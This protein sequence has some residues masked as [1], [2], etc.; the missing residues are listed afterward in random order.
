ML[1]NRQQCTGCGACYNIC[2]VGC[3]QMVPDA[4]GFLAPVVD[5]EQCTGCGQCQKACPE[6]HLPRWARDIAPRVFACWNSNED[7]RLQS[8]SGGLFSAL[9][10]RIFENGG[11]VVGA[12]YAEEL[13]VK[14]IL[15]QDRENAYRLR[16]SKY[17]QSDMGKTYQRVE[18]RLTSGIRVLF[19]GTPCQ[20]A[21]LRG[22]LGKEY[23][24]L[25][26]CDIL[27]HGVPSPL[28]FSS[29]LEYLKNFLGEEVAAINCRDKRYD[30]QRHAVF[31]RLVNSEEKRLSGAQKGY[32]R[33]FYRGL[34]LREACYECRYCSTQRV[35]DISLGDFWGIGKR[36]PFGHPTRRGVSLGIVNTRKGEEL[37]VR[38]DSRLAYEMRPL[39]EAVAGNNCLSLT[40]GRHPDRD[41]FYQDLV[42]HG[43]ESVVR[44]Y[45]LMGRSPLLQKVAGMKAVQRI[46]CGLRS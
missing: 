28:C 14:H 16:N 43:F 44:K 35:G 40:T 26:T 19:S 2:P 1:C 29:Y 30:W 25:I 13:T 4:E 32:F 6:L 8:A 27:C 10:E 11:T 36:V 46:L 21:G 41:E 38:D 24:N 9:A 39:E 15:V 12:T 31:V 34:S 37:F 45:H 17:V 22:F 3:I 20:V 33:A 7:I 42:S 5:E 18:E 23:D